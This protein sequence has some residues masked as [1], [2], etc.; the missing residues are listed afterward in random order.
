MKL[1]KSLKTKKQASETL[2]RTKILKF[3]VIR[4]HIYIE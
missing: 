1:L 4:L 2:A 3:Q